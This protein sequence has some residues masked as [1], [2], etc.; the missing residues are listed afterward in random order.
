MEGNQSKIRKVEKLASKLRQKQEQMRRSQTM[1]NSLPSKEPNQAKEL[2]CSG[3]GKFLDGKYEEAQQEFKDAL[4]YDPSL[5][6]AYCYLGIISLELGDVDVGMQWCEQGLEIDP[7]NGYL[8]YCL[9]AAFERKGMPYAAIEQ[10]Q[11]YLKDHPRDAECLF[12]LGCA[13]DQA[14]QYQDALNYYR[15]TLQNDPSHYKASYNLALVLGEQGNTSDA[16]DYL[17]KTVETN[18]TYWKG[19]IK[20]GLFYS[21]E[22]QWKEAIAAYEK[23]TEMRPEV[24]DSHYNLGLCYLTANKSK[25]ATKHFKEAIRLNPEDADSA[26][27]LAVSYLD[28]KEDE[29]AFQALQDALIIDLDHEKAHYLLGRLYYLKG[30]KEKGDK[31]LVF[32]EKK[33]SNFAEALRACIQENAKPKRKRKKAQ[34]S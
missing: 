13:Y 16:I 18:P 10:Y 7:D 14:G 17:K 26:F 34:A 15:Q 31:E 1:G 12:S 9:G 6:L 30:E 25:K 11:I 8:H 32:L 19:W 4:R 5:P 28:L 24:S 22:K 20:L 27:Y 33:Q 3:V 29:A 2:F 21:Y 23:A